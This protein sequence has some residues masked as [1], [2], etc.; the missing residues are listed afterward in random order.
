M[1]E[2]IR[3]HGP[4]PLILDG[5]RLAHERVPMLSVR[6]ERIAR[7]RG[8]PPHLGLVAFARED[9]RAPF[10][11]RK[12]R[13]CEEAGVRVTARILPD[14]ATTGQVR[15]AIIELLEDPGPNG[16]ALDGLFLEFP[17]PEGVD[18]RAVVSCIPERLDIDVM[19]EG[20]IHRYLEE[21]EGPPP[22]TVAAG[23]ALLD[24][25]EVDVAGMD[26]VVVGDDS[27]FTRIF[28][29][30][31][32]RRG[33]RMRPITSPHAPD[34]DRKIGDVQL[35]VVSIGQPGRVRANALAPGAVAIDVG[36]YN[37]GG[38][39]DIDLSGGIAHLTAL[40]PVPG[41]IGP[42]TVSMLVERIIDFAE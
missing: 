16:D 22:L 30:A 28:S 2:S 1:I 5:N 23:L 25:Y 18:E 41:G 19:T 12:T 35:V 40:A 38:R 20:C 33:A 9:G 14:R 6:A 26:G 17:F 3:P 42:M 39:G 15:D 8:R 4:V 13:A 10:A 32:A 24:R 34:L 21:G 7:R 11:A 36:Y 37:P 27:P 29:T 31:L